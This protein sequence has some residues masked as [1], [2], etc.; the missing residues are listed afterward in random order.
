MSKRTPKTAAELMAELQADRGFTAERDHRAAELERRE[1][2]WREA[3]TPLVGELGAAG[4]AVT[5]VWDLVNTAAPYPAAVPILLD[6]LERPYPDRVREGIARALAVPEAT[7]GAA[8]LVALYRREPAETDAKQGL[9]VALAQ[10][11][12]EDELAALAA[13]PEHG[14][15]RMLLLGGLR[16]SREALEALTRDREIGAEARR[17][18]KR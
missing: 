15:S 12:S 7:S 1:A 6:H 4:V 10:T 18:L 8:A 2:A 13:A 16:R 14:T 5:S 9:A 11:A 3:E 17:L